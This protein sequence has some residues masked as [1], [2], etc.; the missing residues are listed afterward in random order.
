MGKCK[1]LHVFKS[2]PAIVWG[3]TGGQEGSEEAAGGTQVRE[4]HS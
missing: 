4:N 1:W 3:E 2:P